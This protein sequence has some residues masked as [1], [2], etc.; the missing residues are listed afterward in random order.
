MAFRWQAADPGDVGVDAK[1]LRA[2]A[3]ALAARATKTL[4]VLK[5]DRV[6]LEYYPEDHGPDKP[7]YSASLAKA[8]VGGVSLMLA[9]DDGLIDPD[10]LACSFIPQWEGDPLRSKI[11]VRHLAT[12]SSGVEDAELSEADRKQ[13]LA[14]GVTLSDQHMSLSGWKGAFWRQEPDPFTLSRDAAPI[15][16][17]PGSRYAYSNPGM[18]LLATCVT[19]SLRQAPHRDIR[20]LLRERVMKP[21]GVGE[22]TW[23]VGYGKTFDVDGLPLVANWGGGSFTARTAAA[24]GRLMLRRGDWEGKRLV[25]QESVDRMTAYAKT[26]LPDRLPGNPQPACGL[27]WYTNFDGNWPQV[28]R[29]AFAGAGAGNQILV[30][31]PSLSMVIVRNGAQIDPQGFW[32]GV[33]TYLFDPIV[34]A[35]QA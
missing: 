21:L 8:L 25:R 4:L 28:L 15:V 1:A 3:E 23:S 35:V 14:G 5:D 10:D 13:A 6:V 33:V 17:E 18:A 16:F 26:P 24:V 30:V 19:A 11:T 31:I 32:G 12:H 7:H 9:M 29:D 34:G 27:A 22:E 20:T 2:A